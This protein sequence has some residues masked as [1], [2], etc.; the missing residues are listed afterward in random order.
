MVAAALALIFVIDL[1]NHQNELDK[2]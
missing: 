2:P 1:E